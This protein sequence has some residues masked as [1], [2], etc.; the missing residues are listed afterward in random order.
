MEE[1][2][3]FLR[4]EFPIFFLCH[5]T[6][7]HFFFIASTHFVHRNWFGDADVFC[8]MVQPVNGREGVKEAKDSVLHTVDCRDYLYVGVLLLFSA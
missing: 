4:L 8:S 1:L 3:I 6:S 2:L 5:R 7:R